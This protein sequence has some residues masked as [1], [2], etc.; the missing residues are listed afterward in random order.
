MRRMVWKTTVQW[1]PISLEMYVRKILLVQKDWTI[2]GV[3]FAWRKFRPT[4][5]QS[6]GIGGRGDGKIYLEKSIVGISR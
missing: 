3:P 5:Y 2:E 6:K 1:I 4:G